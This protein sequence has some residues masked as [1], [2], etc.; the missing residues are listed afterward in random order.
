M[1]GTV[2]IGYFKRYLREERYN[3]LDDVILNISRRVLCIRTGK[4]DKETRAKKIEDFESFVVSISDQQLVTGFALILAAYL[5]RYGVADL[6]RTISAYSYCMAVNLALFSC[7]VHLSSMTVLRTYHDD[8]KRSRDLRTILMIVAVSFLIPQLV[9]SQILDSSR[10][11]RCA[12]ADLQGDTTLY[13][14]SDIYDQTIFFGTLAILGVL[15]C[16]YLR[17]MLEM[18]IPRFRQSPE[19]ALAELCGK[20]LP[21]PKESDLEK[22]NTAARGDQMAKAQWLSSNLGGARHYLVLMG[23]LAGELRTSF[24]AEIVWLLFYFTFGLCQVCFFIRWGSGPGGSESPISFTPQFGQLLPIGMLYLPV[25]SA[26]EAYTRKAIR[27]STVLRIIL[28]YA[29]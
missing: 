26:F 11:L 10:T 25:L 13:W 4:A 12:V 23:V 29:A 17:R 18:Y 1:L 3:A 22:F 6:D 14:Y 21:W 8:N 19:A 5:I 28:T 9:T 27:I 2:I 15:V 7:V 20:V 24:F 16:G